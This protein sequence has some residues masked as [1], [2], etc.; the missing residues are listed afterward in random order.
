[1]HRLKVGSRETTNKVIR[2][3]AFVCYISTC[4]RRYRLCDDEA[5]VASAKIEMNS[6]FAENVKTSP[7]QK[8]NLTGD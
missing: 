6:C 2:Q 4:D 3:S 1:M 8:D 7:D 5:N